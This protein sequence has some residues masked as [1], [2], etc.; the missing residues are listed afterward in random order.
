[1]T[2]D[3][4]RTRFVEVTSEALDTDRRLA[5]LTAVI[6]A[7]EFV[8]SGAA[9]RHPERV[10]DVGIR[11]QLLIGAAAGMALEGFRPVVH[12]YAP[13]LVERPFEQIKLDFGHQGLDGVLV[14]IGASHDWAEGGRTHQAPGDVALMG[15]LPGWEIH[16]PGHP[17]EV[18]RLLRHALAGPG[19]HYLRL[20][21]A[22]NQRAVAVTPGRTTV[23]RTGR[24]GSAT[25]V[26]VG[27]MLDPVLAATADLDLTVVYAATVRPFDDET[28]RRVATGVDIVLVEP[29]L[30]GTSAGEVGAAL[31]DRPTR[32]LAVG[33][34]KDELRKYG[35]A[36]EHDRAHG[37]D[38]ASLRSRI[39]RFLDAAA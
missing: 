22:A 37:L 20:S 11:E 32:L 2:T 21:A 38:P 16:V 6:S 17:D 5:V 15:T 1:M 19:S 10:I 23:L 36:D 26:A 27:P 3:T 13:F 30:E 12:T 14:S 24:P 28:L 18:E 35:S 7:R 4:M 9:T 8:A 31:R 33:V 39:A 25:V 29:Y 34:G